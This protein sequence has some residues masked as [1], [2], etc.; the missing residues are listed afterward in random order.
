MYDPLLISLKAPSLQW[1][2][3]SVMTVHSDDFVA[4]QEPRDDGW[5]VLYG[6]LIIHR[7]DL[8]LVTV[9]LIVALTITITLP[10]SAC[11]ASARNSIWLRSRHSCY[12]KIGC[13]SVCQCQHQEKKASSLWWVG[14]RWVRRMVTMQLGLDMH[15]CSVECC[16][17]KQL[18]VAPV[19]RC[20]E[21]SWSFP[22][23]DCWLLTAG[24]FYFSTLNCRSR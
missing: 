24:D 17:S 5:Q 6:Q 3:L 2:W 1:P 15:Q 10:P 8:K 23:S 21:H 12:Y 22:D 13:V 4:Y 9:T 16:V 19:R 20:W 11:H 14:L 18:G 7:D